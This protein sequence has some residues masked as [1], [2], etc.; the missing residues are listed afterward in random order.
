MR[1]TT[2]V[3]VATIALFIAVSANAAIITVGGITSEWVDVTPD[4]VTDLRLFNGSDP[5]AVAWGIPHTQFSGQS[6]FVFKN[7]VTPF[8]VDT[9]VDSGLFFLGDFTHRNNPVTGTSVSPESVGLSISVSIDGVAG[10]FGEVFTLFLDE[11]PNHATAEDPNC[12][13]DFVTFGAGTTNS[14]F[15]LGGSD[16]FIRLLG[17]STDGG[18]T[19]LDTFASPERGFNTAGLWGQ[20]VEGRPVVA[21]PAPSTLLLLG[22]ALLAVVGLRRR[23]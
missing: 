5:I 14:F 4:S 20:I 2:S 21:V 10:S 16:Y 23:T 6:A 11:T 18:A 7:A 15:T 9:E 12:C 3:A 13:D 1:H 22:S 8:D 19:L 17:F